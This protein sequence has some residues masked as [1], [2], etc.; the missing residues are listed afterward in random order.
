MK[1]IKTSML[2]YGR[3]SVKT[4][5]MSLKKTWNELATLLARQ[6]VSFEHDCLFRMVTI[7]KQLLIIPSNV[8]QPTE[9]LRAVDVAKILGF[10]SN[11]PLRS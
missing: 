7:L 3:L 9:E 8:W 10:N 6:S 4:G 5:P 11:S 2:R 1:D